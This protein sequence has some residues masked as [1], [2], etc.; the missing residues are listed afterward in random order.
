[1]FVDEMPDRIDSIRLAHASGDVDRLR[2]L[3]HQLKGAAGSHGF[4]PISDT[5]ARLEDSIRSGCPEEQ[6]YQEVMALTEICA[7]AR[8]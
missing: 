8:R 1:M 5:A 2:R 4:H 7:R 3:A 6:V